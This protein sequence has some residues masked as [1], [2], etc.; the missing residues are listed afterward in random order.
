MLTPLPNNIFEAS[1]IEFNSFSSLWVHNDS[2]DSARIY[3]IDTLGNLLRTLNFTNTTAIDFEDITQDEKGNYYI[4]DFGNNLS[5]RKDLRILKIKNP[6][7]ISANSYTP[8]VISFKYPDQFQFPPDSNHC[9]FDCEGMFHRN[10]S[11]YIFSK[12]HGSSAYSRLY[13]IPDN[14]G[15]YIATLVDSFNTGE[16]VTAADISPDGKAALL[17]SD[18]TIWI[19]KNFG[20]HTIFDGQSE[21]IHLPATQKEGIVFIN[22]TQVLII[23]EKETIN[24]DGQK[25]YFLDLSKWLTGIGEKFNSAFRALAF[26]N[27]FNSSTTIQLNAASQNACLTICTIFGQVVKSIDGVGDKIKLERGNLPNGIYFIRLCQ[28]DEIIATEKLVITD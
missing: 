2:G 25:L 16:W 12:N 22:N 5:A 19:F 21:K 10:D 28:K 18:S 17:L 13:K 26:P 11:L 15:N 8:D 20:A 6:D 7:S 23:D 3:K 14:P 1:G 27:P 9:N 24:V 4:G